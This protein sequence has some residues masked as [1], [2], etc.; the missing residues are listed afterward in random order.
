MCSPLPS[1]V[2][3][4]MLLQLAFL[5]SKQN[6]YWGCNVQQ[7]VTRANTVRYDI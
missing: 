3:N 4:L 2:Q 6:E 5:D 7:D 1:L